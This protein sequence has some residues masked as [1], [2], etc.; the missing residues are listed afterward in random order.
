M[1]L[2][3]QGEDSATTIVRGLDISLNPKTISRVTTLPLEFLWRKEEKEVSV[4]AKKNFFIE[5]ENPIED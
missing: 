2:H 1:A 4:T 5:R 3:P